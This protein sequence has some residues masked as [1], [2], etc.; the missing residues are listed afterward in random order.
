LELLIAEKDCNVGKKKEY[1][2]YLGNLN[3]K[4]GNYD[5]GIKFFEDI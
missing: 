1:L 4:M 3:I 5:A 2:M